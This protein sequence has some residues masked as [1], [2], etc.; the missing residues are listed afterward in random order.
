VCALRGGRMRPWQAQMGTLSSDNR[1][2]RLS[3]SSNTHPHTWH[4]KLILSSKLGLDRLRLQQSEVVCD[5][6]RQGREGG[7][8]ERESKSGRAGER[9]IVGL[10]HAQAPRWSG[11]G[12]TE[13]MVIKRET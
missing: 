2:T 6:A 8:G 1:N 9:E 5:R 7:E 11:A 4:C 3:S 12:R 10:S 13:T